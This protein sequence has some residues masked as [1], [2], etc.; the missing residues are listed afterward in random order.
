MRQRR[1]GKSDR[2]YLNEQVYSFWSD[3]FQFFSGAQ[4]HN[5]REKISTCQPTFSDHANTIIRCEI[6]QG[7][8]NVRSRWYWSLFRDKTPSTPPPKKG[9][10]LGIFKPNRRKLIFRHNFEMA[11]RIS[12]IFGSPN[13]LPQNAILG[14]PLSVIELLTDFYSRF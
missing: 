5:F 9:A 4:I 11:D 13:S 8:S 10:W 14:T 7:H 3:P 12:N 6:T 1:S 2:C